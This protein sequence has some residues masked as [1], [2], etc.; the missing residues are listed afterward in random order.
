MLPGAEV[1]IRCRD[2]FRGGSCA[3]RGCG[4]KHC[5]PLSG[6]CRCCP[7]AATLA[8]QASVGT[9]RIF[10]F[11]CQ[12]SGAILIIFVNKHTPRLKAAACRAIVK[13]QP[14]SLFAYQESA[15][16]R[17]YEACAADGRG[18]ISS[19]SSPTRP[20]PMS[21]TLA[22]HFRSHPQAHERARWWRVHMIFTITG[23]DRRS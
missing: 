22:F 19:S 7:P 15:A 2:L 12:R 5:S 17:L 21:L 14:A 10:A 13:A 23:C 1:S 11:V 8:L 6:L 9:R 16:D 4:S 3:A 20:A 18:C